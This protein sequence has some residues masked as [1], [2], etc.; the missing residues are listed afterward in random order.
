MRSTRLRT[1]SFRWVFAITLAILIG[2]LTLVCAE[3][4][5]TDRELSSALSAYLSDGILHD[6][7]DWGSGQHVLVV[8]QTEPQQPGSWKWRW[9]HLLDGRIKSADSSFATRC[10]FA[11][12]NALPRDLHLRLRLPAGIHL[13][14]ARRRELEKTNF[15]GEFQA[16]FPNNLGYVAVSR[17]GL[18]L[19]KTEA[20]FYIDHFCGLCGGGRFVLM[21]KVNGSWQTVEEHYTWIS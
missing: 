18:N 14:N 3:Q 7:H 12:S 4:W 1:R 2:A 10:S 13:A 5:R 11:L 16:R 15:T 20:I 8:L 9:L 17:A 19:S 6:A 21:R